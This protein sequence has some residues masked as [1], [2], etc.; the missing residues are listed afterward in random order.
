[1]PEKQ[2]YIN[3]NVLSLSPKPMEL[4]T[5]IALYSGSAEMT[6]SKPY[7]EDFAVFEMDHSVKPFGVTR[8]GFTTVILCLSGSLDSIVG[9]HH[10]KIKAHDIA[11]IPAEH[12]NTLSGFSEDF[13]AFL[14]VFKSDFLKKG[15]LNTAILDELLYINPDYPPVFQL[16]SENF[17]ANHYKFGK[18]QEE[19][20]KA[21][22]FFLDM[23]RLYL[24]QILFD[25]N[26]VCEIC[27]LNS[28]TNMNRQFQIVHKFRK[29]IDKHFAT[30]KTVKEYA[31]LL[32]ISPKYLSECT[33]QQVGFSAIDLIHQRI[34]LEA[35]FLLRYSELTIKEISVFLNFDTLSHFGRFFKSQKNRTPTE[36][37]QLR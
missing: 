10:F 18:I 3:T 19:Q 23:I 16:D 22:P 17:E 34:V 26:R 13:K 20:H 35:E 27:L 15:F 1:M 29:L 30:L 21:N 9:Q 25:Y 14:I 6:P 36:Y 31:D 28:T 32:H 33:K 37:R 24:V 12:I 11:I 5:F 4:Q 8:F 7:Q 2:R